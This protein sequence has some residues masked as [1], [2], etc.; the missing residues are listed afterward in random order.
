[1]ANETSPDQ[2][3]QSPSCVRWLVFALACAT[4]F[5]LYVHR[6]SWNIVGPALQSDLN[7]SN[8]QIGFLFSLFYY[9]YAAGQIPSGVTVD[10]FGPHR[11]LSAVIAIWSIALA[12]LA[13]TTNLL[14]LGCFRLLFGAAQAGC[15]PALS[16]MTRIWFPLSQRTVI[17]GF[18]ATTFG[19]AG[20]ALSPILMAT[21]LIGYMHLSWQFALLLLSAIGIFHSILFLILCRDSPH[22]DER[23]NE[24]ERELIGGGGELVKRESN[25]RIPPA[26]ALKNRSMKFFTVQQF[27]SAGSD[28]VFVGLI[29]TYFLEVHGQDMKQTGILAS[30]PL[31]GGALGGIAGGMLNDGL[32][33]ITGSRRWVRSGVGMAGKVIGCG[34][35]VAVIM[36]SDPVAAALFLAASKF[37]SDWS[38]PTTWGACTDLGGRLSA[39]VLGII[40]TAGTIGGVVMPVIFGVVLDWF[41]T[42]STIDGNL[43][44]VTDW[45]PLFVILTV[46]Y[47]ASGLCWLGVDCTRRI[48]GS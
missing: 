43:V 36:Q 39:T 20:G 29:G 21:L 11:F 35:L 30:L 19:R 47:L 26:A 16:K 17:Q 31:W 15:Y 32:I 3:G 41:T 22:H 48:G 18:I 6:Y 2:A 4:S 8:A 5:L 23:V 34:M 13:L 33:R 40:N 12:C 25:E 14:F 10:R 37:F 24:A 44:N 38:Q 28:V 7:L 45:N 1:M 42:T 9:T 46:M 27:F